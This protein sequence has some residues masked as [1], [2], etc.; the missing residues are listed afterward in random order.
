M[1]RELKRLVLITGI[2]CVLLGLSQFVLGTRLTP[3][4]AAANATT[5]SAERFA[6]GIL[7]GFGLAWLWAARVSPLPLAV[8]RFLACVLLLGATGRIIS[9]AGQ[10][11]PHWFQLVQTIVEIVV[12]ALVLIVTAVVSRRRIVKTEPR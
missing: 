11:W 2:V 3:G 5:E 6:G 12:P 4:A 7:I 10:G 9:V 1:T 8:V